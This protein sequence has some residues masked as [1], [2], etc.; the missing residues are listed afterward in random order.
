MKKKKVEG[1]IDNRRA[2]DGGWCARQGSRAAEKRRESEG[3]G[4]VKEKGKGKEKEMRKR[5]WLTKRRRKIE[6][7][8][9]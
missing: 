6:Q 8:W 7:T 3:K 5:N 2:S 4:D 9:V 1:R